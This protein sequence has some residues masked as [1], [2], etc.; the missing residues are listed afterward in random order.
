MHMYDRDDGFVHFH[1]QAGLL[2]HDHLRSGRLEVNILA[3]IE[4]LYLE[5]DWRAETAKHEVV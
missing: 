1:D 4:E 2:L 3:Q 5:S